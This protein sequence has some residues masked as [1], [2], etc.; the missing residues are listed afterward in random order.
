[1]PSPPSKYF[2]FIIAYVGLYFSRDEQWMTISSSLYFLP[3]TVPF[4]NIDDNRVA[5]AVS[6]RGPESV[7]EGICNT[8]FLERYIC[9][10]CFEGK[11]RSKIQ[12]NRKR[13]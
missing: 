13:A 7:S 1:M 9:I 11:M 3:I 2:F 8:K 5:Q 10:Q 6:H 4:S 12:T